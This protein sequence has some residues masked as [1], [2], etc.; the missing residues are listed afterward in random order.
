MLI[1]FVSI[2]VGMV[3]LTSEFIIAASQL[4]CST[5]F[6]SSAVRLS[7]SAQLLSQLPKAKLFFFYFQRKTIKTKQNNDISDK[8]KDKD[9]V[10]KQE[11]ERAKPET[12]GKEGK[13]LSAEKKWTT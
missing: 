12:F 10:S 9:K 6:L 4:S 1:S 8:V 3:V 11:T 13:K 7:C 2:F 5:P